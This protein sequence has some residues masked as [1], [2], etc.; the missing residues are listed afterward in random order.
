MNASR[1][2]IFVR[3][4]GRAAHRTAAYAEIREDSCG[5]HTATDLTKQ[6]RKKRAYRGIY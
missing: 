2:V 5:R 1:D 4:R 6:S 3:V